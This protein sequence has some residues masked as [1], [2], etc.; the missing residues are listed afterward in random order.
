MVLA[1]SKPDP[2]LQWGR[3]QLFAEIL[4]TLGSINPKK[5]HKY[6]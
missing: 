1:E 6:T 4:M 2:P 3:D 5:R